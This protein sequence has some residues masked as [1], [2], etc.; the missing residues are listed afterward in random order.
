MVKYN[1]NI[2]SFLLSHEAI[3]RIT[4]DHIASIPDIF[5]YS[6]IKYG[7]QTLFNEDKDKDLLQKVGISI[8]CYGVLRQM[9]ILL[10]EIKDAKVEVTVNINYP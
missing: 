1:A 7:L 2:K 9:E 6:K 3:K 8:M 4:Q 5:L 10:I